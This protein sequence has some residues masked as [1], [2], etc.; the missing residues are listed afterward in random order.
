MQVFGQDIN[1][2][3]ENKKKAGAYLAVMALCMGFT[4]V[5]AIDRF[6]QYFPG[7]RQK[8]IRNE[9]A[10]CFEGIVA[11]KLFRATSG[12]RIAAFEILLATDIT[13]NLI[14]TAN[15]F[16]LSDYMFPNAGMQTFEESVQGLRNKHLI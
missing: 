16:K 9:L 12:G 15:S 14:R 7:D 11:Q 1:F 6:V 4:V 3:I 8:E 10:N 2:E 5:E 13:R